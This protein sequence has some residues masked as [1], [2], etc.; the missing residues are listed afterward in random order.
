M[1]RL[2]EKQ[3]SNMMKQTEGQKNPLSGE[4]EK[5]WR[6]DEKDL[7]DWAHQFGTSLTPGMVILLYG[8]MG[9][10]KTTLVRH[11]MKSIGAEEA[12]SPTFSIVNEYDSPLGT[13]YHFDLYR[14]E[15]EEELEDIGFEEYLES[16]NICLIEWPELGEMFYP[17]DSKA[18]YIRVME[19]GRRKVQLIKGIA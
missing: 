16:G 7:G 2:Q 8:A 6:L 3:L 18:L 1:N 4:V 9:S 14:L 5:E 12:S 17:F 13:I 19:D 10:G 15:K 11:L